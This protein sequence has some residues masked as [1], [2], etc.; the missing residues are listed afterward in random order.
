MGTHRTVSLKG[1]SLRLLGPYL[2]SL[3]CKGYSASSGYERMVSA[4]T[5]VMSLWAKA[6]W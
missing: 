4:D 2:G 1:K 6:R 3:Y 5:G